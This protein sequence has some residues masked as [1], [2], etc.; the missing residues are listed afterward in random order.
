MVENV[1]DDPV[2]QKPSV[3]DSFVEIKSSKLEAYVKVEAPIKVEASVKV[4][5]LLKWRLQASIPMCG[6][7]VTTKWTRL[8]SFRVERH[9]KIKTGCS[10]GYVDKQIRL[11]LRLSLNHLMQLE[12]L[13]WSWF[14]KGVAM[15]FLGYALTYFLEYII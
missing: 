15:Y 9:G 1:G 6:N 14:V 11:D 5:L 3:V 12:I 8:I 10:V 4:N 13:C 7:F 2:D